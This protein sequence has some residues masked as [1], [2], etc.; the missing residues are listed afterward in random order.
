MA[1]GPAGFGAPGPSPSG[2]GPQPAL[3]AASLADATTEVR[4]F[5]LRSVTGGGGGGQLSQCVVRVQED[6]ADASLGESGPVWIE[7]WLARASGLSLLL[8]KGFIR[9]GSIRGLHSVVGF[10]GKVTFADGDALHVHAANFSGAA[11]SYRMDLQREPRFE[12][13]T[14]ALTRLSTEHWAIWAHQSVFT[15]AN[16]AGGAIVVD[17]T[18]GQGD[19]MVVLHANGLNSGTNT[20]QIAA[21]DEDNNRITVYSGIASGATTRGAIP[22]TVSNSATSSATIDSSDPDSRL[23]HGDDKFTIEQTGA[24]AQNNT[25]TINIRAKIRGRPPAISKARS[26]NQAD[27]TQGVPT[28]DRVL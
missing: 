16:A 15:Q 28:I 26:T 10:V 7:L 3:P 1:V 6:V 27:V 14:F 23:F 9:G 5:T 24:G 4:S 19:A 12:E 25:L 2:F 22:Q 8:D 17:F 11:V 20:I 21:Y 13:G 18:P